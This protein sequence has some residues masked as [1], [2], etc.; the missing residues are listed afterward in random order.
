MLNEG[1]SFLANLAL[2][3]R[4]STVAQ[5]VSNVELAVVPRVSDP[6]GP[7]V[8]MPQVVLDDCSLLTVTLGASGRCHRLWGMCLRCILG[9][10]SHHLFHELAHV[11]LHGLLDTE[12]VQG[13][14]LLGHV[15]CLRL[16]NQFGLG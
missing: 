3:L 12:V 14:A 9:L 2:V 7:V 6:L 10:V 15:R 1:L 13:A 16:L 11:L 4:E 8:L 5:V